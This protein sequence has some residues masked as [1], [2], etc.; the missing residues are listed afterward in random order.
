[1][2]VESRARGTFWERGAEAVLVLV[3]RGDTLNQNGPDRTGGHGGAR[4]LPE[5]CHTGLQ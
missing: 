4:E 5:T 2:E 1:M 3:P